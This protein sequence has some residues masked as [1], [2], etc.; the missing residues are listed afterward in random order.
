M[1]ISHGTFFSLF[2]FFTHVFSPPS[3]L[4]PFFPL[5]FFF[6]FILLIIESYY[7]VARVLMLLTF[8]ACPSCLPVWSDPDS[9]RGCNGLALLYG[10][11]CRRLGA[12]CAFR[13]GRRRVTR[14]RQGRPRPGGSNRRPSGCSSCRRACSCAR[15]TRLLGRIAG[16]TA[17]R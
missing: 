10:R 16:R 6:F 13:C 9:S 3:P 2:F 7:S 15:K 4:L 12:G 1:I 5:K 14:T 8:Q 17:K 11:G